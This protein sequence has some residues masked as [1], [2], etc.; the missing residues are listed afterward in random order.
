M[1]LDT[2]SLE[3]LHVV[4][5]NGQLVIP[6]DWQDAEH[7]QAHLRKQEINTTVHLEPITKESRLEVWPGVDPQQVQH[8]LDS[9]EGHA[10]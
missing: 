2:T 4:E 6:V 5:Q 8:A 3:R 1:A 7:L 9:W 10:H